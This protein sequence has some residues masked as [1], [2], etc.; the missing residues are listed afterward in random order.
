MLCTIFDVI[1]K[2]I[3]FEDGGA[4]TFHAFNPA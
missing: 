2:N 4:N 1:I 3:L